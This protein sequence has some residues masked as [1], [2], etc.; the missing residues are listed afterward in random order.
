[1]P[2]VARAV[3]AAVLLGVASF[4]AFGFA[5][6]FEPL[7]GHNVLAWRLGYGG[8]ALLALLGAAR[9]ARR[10]RGRGGEGP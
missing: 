10:P 3:L 6:T 2:T 1:M 5:A 4:C 7:E 9:L 8:G